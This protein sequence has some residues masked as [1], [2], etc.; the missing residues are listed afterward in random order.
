P[1]FFFLNYSLANL[2]VQNFIVIPKYY[3]IDDIIE[4]RKPLAATARRAGWIGCNILLN[5]IPSTGRIFLVKNGEVLNKKQVIETWAKTSFISKQS[6]ESKGWTL[7]ILK[8]IERIPNK[9]F[10]LDD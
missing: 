1:H 4:K 6:N 7:E 8:L 5:N 9:E 2:S 10:K 3:F